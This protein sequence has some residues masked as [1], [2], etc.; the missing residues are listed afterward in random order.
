MNI[1]INQPVM[2][3]L[4]GNPSTWK[5]KEVDRVFSVGSGYIDGL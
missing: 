5:V 3:V 1:L 2:E 4:M